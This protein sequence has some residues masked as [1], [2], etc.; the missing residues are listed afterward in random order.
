MI[1]NDLQTII[2]E[3]YN[4]LLSIIDSRENL[5]YNENLIEKLDLIIKK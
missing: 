4:S 3:K 5:T 2:N 1:K